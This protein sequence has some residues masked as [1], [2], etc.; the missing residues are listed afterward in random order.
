MKAFRISTLRGV[1]SIV[2]YVAR[3]IGGIAIRLAVLLMSTS[4]AQPP[5]HGLV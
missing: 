3:R 5:V 2:V 4:D 1:V